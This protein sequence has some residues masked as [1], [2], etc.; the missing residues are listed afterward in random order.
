MSATVTVVEFIVVNV[1]LTVRLPWIFTLPPIPTP[2]VTTNAPELYVVES[3][4]SET[5]TFDE[6][7]FAPAI[8]CACVE[9]KPVDP[10]LANGIFK[11][12]VDVFELNAG[13]APVYPISNV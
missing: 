1:P 8:V 6:K 3:V 2:P 4:V 5:I 10:E 7:V 9:I 13:K 11:V 12:W